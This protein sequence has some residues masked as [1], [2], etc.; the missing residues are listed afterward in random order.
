MLTNIPAPVIAYQVNR[1]NPAAPAQRVGFGTSGYRGSSLDYA[2]SEAHILAITQAICLYR[3]QPS[4]D[5]RYSW[6]SIRTL[7]RSGLSQC[8][9]G[10]A[11][12]ARV[13]AAIQSFN[14]ID[15]PVLCPGIEILGFLL[16]PD[17]TMFLQIQPICPIST[18][19]YNIMRL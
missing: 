15:R 9:G 6:A 10:H 2:C 1:F 13:R 12:C 7:C 4:I 17:F 19:P 8:V 5:G 3:K 11:G 14:I 16:F 18:A